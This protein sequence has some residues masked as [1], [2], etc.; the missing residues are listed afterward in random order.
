MGA[1]DLKSMEG[2]SRNQSANGSAHASSMASGE[3]ESEL[4]ERENE[5]LGAGWVEGGAQLQCGV[6]GGPG[7]LDGRHVAVTDNPRSRSR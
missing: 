1:V 3:R 4:R 6:R 7:E 5:G 2:S